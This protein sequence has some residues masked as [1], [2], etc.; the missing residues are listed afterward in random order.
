MKRKCTR[1][2]LFW[3]AFFA[4]LLLLPCASSGTQTQESP[5]EAA[6]KERERKA[7][8]K[9]A[10]R[11]MTDDDLGPRTQEFP[12]LG[13]LFFAPEGWTRVPQENTAQGVIQFLCPEVKRFQ[14]GCY[15][16]LS[17]AKWPQN[18][19]VGDAEGYFEKT[20]A[21]YRAGYGTMTP[22]TVTQM[23]VS[24]L[25]AINFEIRSRA[26]SADGFVSRTVH[27]PVPAKK[28]VYYL[29]FSAPPELSARHAKVFD[30]LL[31]SFEVLP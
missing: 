31:Q 2:V 16:Q 27:L 24:R 8:A 21:T 23:V 5:A 25:P 26:E 4:L 1:I 11:K 22:F 6:R 15:F 14:D 13:A 7:S 30:R 19:R 12:E 10:A 28:S 9:K 20:E 18:S 3:S 17:K 29:V